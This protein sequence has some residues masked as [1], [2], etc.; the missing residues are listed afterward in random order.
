MLNL[1][2][3]TLLRN[4]SG[5]IGNIA[6]ITALDDQTPASQLLTNAEVTIVASSLSTVAGILQTSNI[7]ISEENAE[8]FNLYFN[9]QK[10]II[11][12]TV[13]SVNLLE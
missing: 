2:T 8:V 13:M 9:L 6:N 10:L 1:N 5:V 4:F 12:C 3:E 11:K 7:N